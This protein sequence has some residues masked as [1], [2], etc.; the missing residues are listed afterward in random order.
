MD[1]E[2]IRL[3]QNVNQHTSLNR[4]YLTLSGCDVY[5]LNPFTQLFESNSYSLG[6][7]STIWGREHPTA[8]AGLPNDSIH[9]LALFMLAA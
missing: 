5:Y 8:A 4:R 7:I 2:S 3:H 6:G 9:A 1:L